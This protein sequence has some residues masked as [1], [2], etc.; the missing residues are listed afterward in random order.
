[1][2]GGPPVSVHATL[3]LS[4]TTWSPFVASVSSSDDTVAL[5]FMVTVERASVP[6]LTTSTARWIVSPA[7]MFVA[8]TDSRLLAADGEIAANVTVP[9]A[10]VGVAEVVLVK[11]AY[12]PT[13]IVSSVAATKPPAIARRLFAWRRTPL[14]LGNILLT[15][16]ETSVGLSE[17]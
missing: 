9:D 8:P 1:M 15:M 5:V 11:V 13:P 2:Y 17:T 6:V 3:H 10:M 14:I 4:I 12:A 7:A 16:T